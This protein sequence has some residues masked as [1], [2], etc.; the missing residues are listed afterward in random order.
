MY[1]SLPERKERVE[2]SNV[3]HEGDQKF[4]FKALG[5]TNNE[6]APQKLHHD[7]AAILVIVKLLILSQS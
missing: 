6:S 5:V 3:P 2:K 1:T 4:L 7:C